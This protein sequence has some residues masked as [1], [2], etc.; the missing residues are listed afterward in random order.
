MYR[1]K[2]YGYALKMEET[3]WYNML[4]N[5]V[6]WPSNNDYFLLHLTP[7]N[8]L[9]EISHETVFR[10]KPFLCNIYCSVN[11]GLG[12][13]QEDNILVG[14]G[15]TWHETLVWKMTATDFLSTRQGFAFHKF[16]KGLN[17]RTATSFQPRLYIMHLIKLHRRWRNERYISLRDLNS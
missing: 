4:I 14:H 8:V 3:S 11:L 5:L 2:F 16:R 12:L 1:P 17:S 6:P 10:S 15:E 13:W 7:D 9:A